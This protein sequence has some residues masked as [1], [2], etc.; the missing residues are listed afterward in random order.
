[1]ETSNKNWNVLLVGNNP[2][3]LSSVMDRIQEIRYQPMVTK[4]AFDLRSSLQALTKF[5]PSYILIDD[6]IGQTELRQTLQQLAHH[7]KTKDTPI[8]IIKNSNYHQAVNEGA[9]N[10]VLKSNLTAERLY[11]TLVQSFTNRAAQKYLQKA[12][13]KR[14]G[15]LL[16]LLKD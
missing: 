14:K 5:S 9:L 3:E 11:K 6:N 2:I 1:M 12:Y 16:R 15:Q 7:R 4:I 10:Y 13:Q 8:T